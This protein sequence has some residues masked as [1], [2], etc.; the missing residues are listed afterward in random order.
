ML[1]QHRYVNCYAWSVNPTLMVS[2]TSVFG[3]NNNELYPIIVYDIGGNQVSM[4]DLFVSLSD[5]RE[6]LFEFGIRVLVS[7]VILVVG[8]IIARTASSMMIRRFDSTV[9]DN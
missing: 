3:Y 8:I 7:L 2:L 4:H 9:I 1:H 6:A 5:N